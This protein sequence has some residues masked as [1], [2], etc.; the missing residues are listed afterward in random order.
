MKQIGSA[1]MMYAQDYDERVG[2][3]WWD[4]H[5]DLE[6]YLKNMDVFTCPGSGAPRPVKRRFASGVFSGY[7][8]AGGDLYSNVPASHATYGNIPTLFGHYARND[9]LLHNFGFGGAG[10]PSMASWE[11]TADVIHYG[12]SRAGNEDDDSNDYDEDNAP[13]FD[14]GAATWLQ[15]LAQES[16]RHNEGMNII[17][18]DGHAKWARWE[19]LRTKEGRYALC[20][21]K[22]DLADTAAF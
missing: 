3:K 22:K 10:S 9:E 15:M 16:R 19:W 18:A 12:E 21:S 5:V 7:F 6:P 1:T 2:R 20:P 4:W 13:Y 11:T 17:Y 8:V 14:P